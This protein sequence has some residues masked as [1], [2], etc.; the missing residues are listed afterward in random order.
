MVPNARYVMASPA[1]LRGRLFGVAG[2]AMMACQGAV[3]V[4]AGAAASLWRPGPTIA[5]FGV[6]G[7]VVTA[8]LTLSR[9]A[10]LPS[11]EPP[12]LPT[13]VTTRGNG[14]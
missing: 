13:A 1:A 3:L 6:L 10:P 11:R 2:T 5:A 9:N 12:K 7:L 8:G 4:A 14:R